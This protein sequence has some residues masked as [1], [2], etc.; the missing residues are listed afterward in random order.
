MSKSLSAVGAD[1]VVHKGGYCFRI[2]LPDSAS[3]AGFVGEVGPAD[4]VA[5]AGGTGKIGVDLAETTW[6]AYA[7]PEKLGES[8]NRTFF[9]SQA[10]DVMQSA[11][12]V[13]KWSGD[14]GPPGKAAFR[15][16]GITAMIAV[17]TAGRDGDVWKVTN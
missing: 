1:G 6:C 11:N 5:L 16:S 13:A 8:G 10:G 17:G 9:V 4:K 7:W 3:P 14:K 15:G 2:F 12:E